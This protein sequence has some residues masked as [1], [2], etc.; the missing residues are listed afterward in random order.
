M[1][2][3][4]SLGLAA[5]PALK[6]SAAAL[7]VVALLLRVTPLG[8]EGLWLD[9]VFGA[10]YVNLKFWEVVVA[11]LRF[12]IHPP[13]YYLQL[14]AWAVV[15]SSDAWLMANSVAW[16][17]GALVAGVYGVRRWAG[18]GAALLAAVLLTV[19]GSE[20]YYA[21]ELRMYTMISCLTIVG[22]IRADIWAATPD[23]RNTLWLLAVCGLLSMIHSS[24]FIP[25][26]SVVLF[27][28]L[29]CWSR[30]GLRRFKP[31]LVLVVGVGALL[32]PW[33]LN[34]SMRSLS[35]TAR[36]SLDAVITTLSGWILGYGSLPLPREVSVVAALAVVLFVIAVL[37][38][39]D[40]KNRLT[41]L[42]FVVWPVLMLGVVSLL[43]R[44]IWINRAVA[45][46]APF[47]MICVALLVHAKVAA[48]RNAKG[49]AAVQGLVALLFAALC[50]VAVGQGLT[51]RKMQYREAAQFLAANNVERLPVHVPVNTTFWAM[52]RYLHGPDWGSLLAVQ[53]PAKVDASD[54]WARLYARLGPE[55]LKMLGLT[56]DRRWIE[57]PSGPLWIGLT[58]LPPDVATRGYWLVGDNRLL[59][60]AGACATGPR[61]G[62]WRFV[63]VVVIHCGRSSI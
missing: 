50:A 39:G 53:D 61:E 24:V 51:A 54:T 11:V 31:M 52:A 20:L 10:S 33:L 32:A 49:R 18:D 63:G 4:R 7:L 8:R 35:H 28:L 47:F 27:G 46:A 16:S 2:P 38:A 44:P 9:E 30:F 48:W 17:L 25:V 21:S 22:W 12:D 55:K 13:L 1:S 40:V 14:K 5:S 23:R 19:A 57:T 37:V 36:P 42:S 6:A 15:S 45:Y 58:E 26:S 56:P 3:N 34:A 41:L 43:L 59:D 60:E 29:S 62:V